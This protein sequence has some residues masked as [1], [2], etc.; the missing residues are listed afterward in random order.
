MEN[1]AKWRIQQVRDMLALDSQYGAGNAKCTWSTYE[2]LQLM[3]LAAAGQ[4]PPL[5]P[6]LDPPLDTTMGYHLWVPAQG[7][8]KFLSPGSCTTE[9]EWRFHSGVQHRAA[10][11]GSQHTHTP[12]LPQATEHRPAQEAL[13]GAGLADTLLSLLLACALLGPGGEPRHTS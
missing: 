12:T 2:H 4:G 3:L 13:P 7:P 11:R 1:D 10:V 6:P 9:A 5:G 8:A